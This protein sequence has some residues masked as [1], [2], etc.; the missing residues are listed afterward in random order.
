MIVCSWSHIITELTVQ[1]AYGMQTASSPPLPSHNAPLL[2]LLAHAVC[3]LP[4]CLS[5]SVT[6]NLHPSPHR[7]SMLHFLQS[8]LHVCH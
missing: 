6:N 7:E 5:V 1:T 8:C 2:H 4:R 3:L